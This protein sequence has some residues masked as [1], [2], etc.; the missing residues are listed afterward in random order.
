VNRNNRGPVPLW[1]LALYVAVLGVISMLLAPLT[2]LWWIVPV[3]G[4]AVP[5]VLAIIQGR[6]QRDVA[7]EDAPDIARVRAAQ[8]PARINRPGL[9]ESPAPENGVLPGVVA[10]PDA[11]QAGTESTLSERE[12]E[13]LALLAK[14]KTNAEAAEALYI[15]V[16]TVKSHS[17]NI[18]RKLEAK[19]RTEAVARARALGLL[20]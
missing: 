11:A 3:L 12:L 18:Y 7:D 20:P 10:S 14:G 6:E 9:D 15:S 19:N 5:V 17:A 1:Q 2:A 4:A 8:V 13:V 16:G